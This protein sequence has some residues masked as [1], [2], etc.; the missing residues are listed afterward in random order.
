MTPTVDGHSVQFLNADTSGHVRPPGNDDGAHLALMRLLEANRGLS[1]RQAASSL[2]MSL[3]K[4]NYVLR[5]PMEKDDRGRLTLSWERVQLAHSGDLAPDL[6]RN[7]VAHV[8]RVNA[9]RF[10]R[11]LDAEAG[12]AAVY[13]INRQLLG[14]AFA[15]QARLNLTAAQRR[16]R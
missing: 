4:V 9:L 1:Q 16:K 15:L 6:L 3:G 12:L 2:G 10:G 5:A 7:D 11:Q 13:E 8:W 14:D